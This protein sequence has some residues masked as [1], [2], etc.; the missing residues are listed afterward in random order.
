MSII[1][2]LVKLVSSIPIT[3]DLHKCDRWCRDCC[4]RGN[5]LPIVTSRYSHT[6]EQENKHRSTQT[7]KHTNTSTHAQEY[8]Y[9][10]THIHTNTKTQTQTMCFPLRRADTHIPSR[11][12][13]NT[14]AGTLKHSHKHNH[15]HKN[16]RIHARIRTHAH[17][18]SHQYIH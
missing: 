11:R 17:T 3:V 1:L 9:K 7:Q 8:I 16:N 14:M 12:G 5:A 10:Y 4:D 2:T 18:K 6:I 13:T 15:M